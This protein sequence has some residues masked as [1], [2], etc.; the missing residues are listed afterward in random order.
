LPSIEIILRL[1][2]IV[3]SLPHTL[4]HGNRPRDAILRL[5]AR[6][7]VGRPLAHRLIRQSSFDRLREPFSR[8]LL[9]RNGLRPNPQR[10]DPSTPE[11]LIA[12]EWNDE[13]GHPR[14]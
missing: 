12:E 14:S 8:Q 6:P 1:D 9:P 3:S 10:R 11:E 13:R 5:N 7:K 4:D 2:G